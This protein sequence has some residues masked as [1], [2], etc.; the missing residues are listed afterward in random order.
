[1]ENINIKYDIFRKTTNKIHQRLTDYVQRP[2]AEVHRY[3]GSQGEDQ[4][5]ELLADDRGEQ[6]GGGGDDHGPQGEG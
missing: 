6:G 5:P 1:M 3:P 4:F 2:Q